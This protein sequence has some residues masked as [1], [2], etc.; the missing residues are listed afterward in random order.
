LA[1]EVAAIVDG[2]LHDPVKLE[3][4]PP[5]PAP[6]SVRIENL[7]LCPRYS[8]LV[9]ENV[10]VAPSP[11]W[12]Q[13]RLS[14]I[15]LNP[16]NNIVDV[17]NYVMAELAQPLHAFDRDLLR[18][19]S[20][21]WRPARGGERVVALNEE[22]Y[23]LDPRDIVIADERGP[24]AVAGVIGRLDTGISERTRGSCWRAPASKPPPSARPR[25]AISC[26][27]TPPCA[28]RRPRTPTTRCVGWPRALELFEEVSPGIRV[29]GGVA[30]TK[31][32]CRPRP[33]SSFR[34]IG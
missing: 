9:L 22:E 21:S 32:S 11:L 6:V 33:P 2:I 34:W 30:D 29:S 17:T 31:R 7:E 10:T 15:G 20:S 23:R 12:L 5:G 27:R 1:R 8:A 16:I 26:G 28:S 4:L 14:A 3:R 25:R 24:I 19:V 13:Y 18:A